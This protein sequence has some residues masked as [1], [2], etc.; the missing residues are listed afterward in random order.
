M[1]RVGRDLVCHAALETVARHIHRLSS[2]SDEPFLL[3]GCATLDGAA[4][5]GSLFGDSVRSAGDIRPSNHGGGP[6]PGAL[7]AAG[8]GTLFLDG[9]EELPPGIQSKLTQ[10]IDERRFHKAGDGVASPFEARILAASELSSACLRER[11]RPQLFHRIAVVEIEV[12]PLRARQADLALLV[13]SFAQKAALDLGMPVRSLDSEAMATVMAYEWPGN[14]RELRNRMIRATSFAKGAKI[15]VKDLFSDLWR[16]QKIEP[17]TTTLEETCCNAER[18]R[19]TEA[20]E[21]NGGRM[22]LAATS[23]GISRVT[24]WT[25]M[26][27]LGLPDGRRTRRAGH[28]G[29][30]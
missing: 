21:A 2:R 16:D 6:Q 10:L 27:K 3:V 25:K 24:L 14:V 13:D 9:V 20:L 23:L 11:L 7:E 29:C 15:G 1:D 17:P 4:G 8:K 26:K 18:R 5:D 22:G 19:I 12:P 28:Q 30:R